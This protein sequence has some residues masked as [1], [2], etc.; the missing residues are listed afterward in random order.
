MEHQISLTCGWLEVS[1][2]A[3]NTLARFMQSSTTEHW[4]AGMRVLKSLSGT[5][6]IGTPHTRKEEE[7]K[8]LIG[9]SDASWANIKD[10]KRSFS[11]F[12]FH[13]YERVHYM[14]KQD[15]TFCNPVNC[16]GRIHLY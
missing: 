1:S 9:Y 4:Q 13:N 5:R 16:R 2:T 10:T 3:A 14:V 7:Q 8:D 6:N 15:P 12:C 11:G